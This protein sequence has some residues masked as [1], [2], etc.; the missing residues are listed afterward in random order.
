MAPVTDD[1]G[2]AAV[3]NV[4]N[5]LGEGPTWDASSG[6]VRWVDIERGTLWAAPLDGDAL[7]APK[8]VLERQPTL[9]AAV[10][11]SDGTF[12]L[13]TRRGLEH[14]DTSG[15]AL[16]S[17]ELIPPEVNSR[18][19]D[20]KCDPA[21][22]YLVGSMALDD[23]Q[24]QERLWRLE[25]DG[26]VSVLDDDLTLSNGLGWSPDGATMYQIDTT[27]GTIYARSYDP[28]TGQAGPRKVL[29]EVR[30]EGRGPDG[31]SI[32]ADGNLWFAVWGA[33]QIRVFSPE[34][35]ELERLATGAPLTTSCAFAGPDL[36]LLVVTSA[37][38]EIPGVQR[39][40]LAGALLTKP[41][42]QRG[43]PTTPWAPVQFRA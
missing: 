32:D 21:G 4:R 8:V 24:G 19:N 35:R 42:A 28:D 10:H 9:G 27:P 30:E 43:L 17:T 14:L 31:L 41:V 20:G 36:D 26:S 15:R 29:L 2:F 5:V 7:G 1:L 22:R 25:A 23:R 12:L 38:Q 34:G 39:T 37:D 33:G 3:G 18:L 16:G 40:A 6:L 11:A 13:A